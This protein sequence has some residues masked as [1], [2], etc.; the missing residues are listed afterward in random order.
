MTL[1]DFKNLN[2]KY[3]IIKKFKVGDNDEF[4]PI[5]IVDEGILVLDYYYKFIDSVNCGIADAN[6]QVYFKFIPKEVIK[7]IYSKFIL[8]E[9]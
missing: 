4:N 2:N 1:E 5:Y 3:N 9:K 7:E 6:E 8:E